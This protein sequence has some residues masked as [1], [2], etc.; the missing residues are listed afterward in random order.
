MPGLLAL[1]CLCRAQCRR[2]GRVE[3]VTIAKRDGVEAFAKM[4]CQK[5]NYFCEIYK[6]LVPA[7]SVP[8][9]GFGL[10]QTRH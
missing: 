2:D 1:T 8:G 9:E 6:L 10:K 5:F 7:C 3:A 4:T